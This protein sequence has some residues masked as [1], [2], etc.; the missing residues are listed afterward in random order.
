MRV[1]AALILVALL[2]GVTGCTGA[3]PEADPTP[4]A[5]TSATPTPAPDP[6][7]RPERRACYRLDYDQA[8]APTATAAP[9]DCSQEHTA[10]TYAVGRLRTVVDGHLLAVDSDRVQRQVAR[11]CPRRLPAYVGGGEEDRRL[12]MLRPV[13]FTPTVAESDAGADWYRCDVIAVAAEDALAPLGRRIDL[14]TPEDRDRYGMCGT[15]EPGTPDFTRVICS[16][17]HSWRAI[18]SVDLDAADGDD[19][20]PGRDVVSAAGE[21]TCREAGRSAAPDPLDFEWGY[22]WPTEEQWDMGRTY[23]L[24]WVPTT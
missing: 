16:A 21:E 6:P 12:S 24:C 19:A 23:G 22:E 5:V 2:S 8:L 7:Q 4:A 20:Y 18:A 11:A 9:V 1:A 3:S 15:A 10:R 17:D 13:W 14:A